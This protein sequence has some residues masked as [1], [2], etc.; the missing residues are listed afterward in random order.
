MGVERSRTTKRRSLTNRPASCHPA[1]RV[2]SAALDC[3]LPWPSDIPR[4]EPRRG[5]RRRTLSAAR[6]KRNPLRRPEC[7]HAGDATARPQIRRSV[8][9]RLGS[10]GPRC[11]QHQA[12]GLLPRVDGSPVAG[13][14][15]PDRATA[16]LCCTSDPRDR[17]DRNPDRRPRSGCR[18]GRRPDRGTL[19]GVCEAQQ[20]ANAAASGLLTGRQQKGRA[21]TLGEGECRIREAGGPGSP[22]GVAALEGLSYWQV[23]RGKREE[24]LPSE[25]GDSKQGYRDIPIASSEANRTQ[26]RAGSRRSFRSDV[27]R[28]APSRAHASHSLT[29]S[30]RRGSGGS[31]LGEETIELLARARSTASQPEPAEAPASWR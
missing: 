13:P 28:Q 21:R 9:D 15:G 18:R 27:S 20:R 31:M 19:L 8:A 26:T 7:E 22:R 16:L 2:R 30:C 17:A 3:L 4:R 10:A 12:P 25:G 23:K 14:A 5:R 11:A 29:A 24:P 1:H 6:G